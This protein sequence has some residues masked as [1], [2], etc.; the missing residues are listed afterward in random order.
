MR[1]EHLLLFGCVFVLLLLSDYGIQAHRRVESAHVY[2]AK[3]QL[4]ASL[5]A[6]SRVRDQMDEVLFSS[7]LSPSILA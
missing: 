1:K 2:D 7:L 6:F 3:S 5:V 4:A